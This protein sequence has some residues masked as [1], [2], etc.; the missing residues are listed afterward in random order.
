MNALMKV[1]PGSSTQMKYYG[2]DVSAVRT[3]GLVERGMALVPEGRRLFPRMSVRE[4]LQLGAFLRRDK[5]SIRS[6]YE[7]VLDM[8][9]ALKQRLKLPAMAL[10]GGQQQ[11]VAIGRALMS[12]PRLLLL[13]EPTIGLAPAVVEQIGD[14]IRSI[15]Q[16][17]VDVLLVEQNAS[18]ALSL[19]SYA[20]VIDR[21]NVMMSGTS[22][23]LASDSRV[24][25]AYLGL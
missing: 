7:R 18:V 16:E 12:A 14:T 11:M 21:G 19:S 6:D 2:E 8:F 13:D 9:P 1:H 5:L 3:N 15:S 17:G 20:Y 25:A 24:R 4:N 22:A 23:A 10:S